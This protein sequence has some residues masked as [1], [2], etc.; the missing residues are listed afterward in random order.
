MPEKTKRERFVSEEALER[1]SDLLEPLS[2][3]FG[4]PMT[5]FD[6]DAKIIREYM[7][8]SS[9]STIDNASG[10]L[11]HQ[12]CQKCYERLRNQLRDIYDEPIEERCEAG[13][14]IIALPVKTEKQFIGMLCLNSL[15]YNDYGT[16]IW[17]SQDQMNLMIALLRSI[18]RQVS[19]KSQ[20]LGDIASQLLNFQNEITLSQRFFNAANGKMNIVALF[21]EAL[22]T[23]QRYIQP[24]AAHIVI[25]DESIL[26][27]IPDEVEYIVK[28]ESEEGEEYIYYII[29]AH[30]P[31]SDSGSLTQ[32][33][34]KNTINEILKEVRQGDSIVRNSAVL[35]MPI[36]K[37]TN[38]VGAIILIDKMNGEIFLADDEKFVGCVSNSLSGVLKQIALAQKIIYAER[39]LVEEQEKLIARVIHKMRNVVLAMN[40]NVRWINDISATDEQI[41]RDDLGLAVA[42]IE[43]NFQDARQLT[44]DFLKYIKSKSERFEPEHTN[45]NSLISEIVQDMR[46]SLNSRIQIEEEY[47]PSLP[48]IQVDCILFRPVIQELIM[49]SSQ[50]FE[51]GGVIWISTGLA[52]RERLKATGLSENSEYIVVKV[53][54]NGPGISGE[55]KP[56][57]F[58]LAFSTRAM[59]T[60]LGLFLVKEEVEKHSG[61]IVEVSEPGEGAKFLILLPITRGKN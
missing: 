28:S 24:L 18:I 7:R 33:I 9:C 42:R 19:E 29:S 55:I 2:N 47:D 23:M 58:N 46:Q 11:E 51:D 49:N 26:S 39:A 61:R 20:D 37:G 44:S 21:K 41:N 30:S 1:I 48:Q 40:G 35:A 34:E 5:L 3:C 4:I 60:G 25:F 27:R 17:T 12:A 16:T 13:V 32:P 31:E 56:R 59:N 50:N 8:P 53:Q 15:F 6:A 38:P 57:I 36:P 22:E 10:E 43:Q 54:D 52:S 14:R 45:I